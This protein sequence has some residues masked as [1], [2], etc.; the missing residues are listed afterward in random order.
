MGKE[1]VQLLSHMLTYLPSQRHSAAQLL[2]NFI[3]TNPRAGNLDI[4]PNAYGGE[5][6]F[7]VQEQNIMVSRRVTPV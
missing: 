6:G 5:L 1:F 2:Q 4:I 3:F 7:L